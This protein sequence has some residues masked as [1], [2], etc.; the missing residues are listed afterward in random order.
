MHITQD[1]GL[2]TVVGL[3]KRR[4]AGPLAKDEGYQRALTRLQL[5]TQLAAKRMLRAVGDAIVVETAAAS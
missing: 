1:G 5:G 3:G 4:G 2:L